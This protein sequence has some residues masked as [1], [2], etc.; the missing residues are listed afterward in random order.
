VEILA[1]AREG[2]PEVTTIMMMEMMMMMMIPIALVLM[3]EMVMVTTF[4]AVKSLLCKF[5]HEDA[6][7]KKV[8]HQT[9]LMH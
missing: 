5:Q 6:R 3:I 7:L 2:H 4:P 9:L 1:S 8:S